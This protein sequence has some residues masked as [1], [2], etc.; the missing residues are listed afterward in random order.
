[1][2][3]RSLN[4]IAHACWFFKVVFLPECFDYVAQ[5]KDQSLALSEPLN[6]PTI[7]SYQRLARENNVWLFLGGF[8]EKLEEVSFFFE[9]L[10]FFFQLCFVSPPVIKPPSFQSSSV[11]FFVSPL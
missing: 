10:L 1:V 9:S 4:L 6:G 2:G 8:H 3:F 5:A 11:F 7:A